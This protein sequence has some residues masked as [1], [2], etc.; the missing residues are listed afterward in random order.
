MCNFH[1]R[2]RIKKK[3]KAELPFEKVKIGLLTLKYHDYGRNGRNGCLVE[4]VKGGKKFKK[5]NISHRKTTSNSFFVFSWKKT[6]I[7][8]LDVAESRTQF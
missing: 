7:K 1:P 5:I 4:L 6:K 3:K 2:G 8:S